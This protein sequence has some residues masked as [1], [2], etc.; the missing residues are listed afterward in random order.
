MPCASG[1]RGNENTAAWL[2]CRPVRT[3]L[4]LLWRFLVFVLVD[5]VV[6]L[7]G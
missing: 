1:N 5:G 4:L 3:L 2:S 6:V 7:V